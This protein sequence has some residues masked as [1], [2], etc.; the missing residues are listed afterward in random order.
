MTLFTPPTSTNR[1]RAFFWVGLVVV[2]TVLIW[3]VVRYLSPE[4]PRTVV[5]STGV[6]DG[7]YHR[8]GQRYQDIFRANGITLELR[9]SSGGVENLERLNAGTV[10]IGLVQGGTGLLALD[11]DA[12]PESTPLRALATIAFE[13]VWIFTHSLDL[14]KGLGPLAGKTIAVGV[15]GS[16]NQRVATQ[17]LWIYGVVDGGATGALDGTRFVEEGGL[18]AANLLQR[19]E[20]DAVIM[21]AAP[22]APAVQRLLA[23]NATHLASLVQVEGLARHLPY[24]QV[25]ELKR[26]SVDPKRDLPPADIKLL[27]TTAN[28]VIREDL[29]PALTYLLLDAARLIHRPPT[30]VSAHDQFPSPRGTDYPLSTEAERYF[31]NGRPLLQSYLPFWVAN[32]AQRLLLLLVPLIAI[33]FPLARLLPVLV[34]WRRESRLFRRYG[35]LRFLEE[36]LAASTL[37][38]SERRAAST[39]LDRIDEE[40]ARTKFPLDFA[41]RV[42]TLRQHVAFV[43]GELTK[44]AASPAA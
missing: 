27:A 26:G 20:I 21:I 42:Y 10:S 44:Q 3:L 36:Q 43:R 29:H 11:P 6:V 18:A 33:L 37:D 41:D 31:K 32:Y 40:I 5:M 14:T 4:P 30:L 17:L 15:A 2:L 23:D 1:R 38:D 25:V 24:F 35:E 7:A 39:K 8:F 13:P 28:L 16:G 34:T 9:P 22:Q 12:D 19:H